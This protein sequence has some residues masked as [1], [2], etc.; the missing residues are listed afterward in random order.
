M[1]HDVRFDEQVVVVTGSGRGL[2]AAYVR[3]FAQLGA[4]VVVH[5]AG[6]D[7]SGTGQDPSVAAAVAGE[8]R[9]RGGHA[10]S[11]T[12]D[13]LEPGA[14]EALIGSAIDQFGRL[15]V[16]VH[17]AG[18]VLWEDV[19]HPSDEIWQRTM[20]INAAAGFQLVRAA[21]PHMRAQ[22]YG[23]VVLTVSERAARVE[24]AAPGLVAYSA[25]KM[26]VYGLMV[27]FKANLPDR[28][29]HLNAISP[30]AATR[31][32]VRDAP[33]LTADSVAPG[34]ALLASRLTTS[35]GRVLWA[36]GGRFRLDHWHEGNTVDLG[37]TPTPEKVARLVDRDG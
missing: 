31:V 33:S 5:D 3:L 17:N 7:Q 14:C 1:M 30:V 24:S 11:S 16:L 8:I 15:D 36:A 32:L 13:L 35:S 34:V 2:G 21:M 23:R 27:G 22:E 20:A 28:D 12:L 9:G 10:M 4:A 25:A 29:I 6:V 37:R 26:A 18:V 19:D